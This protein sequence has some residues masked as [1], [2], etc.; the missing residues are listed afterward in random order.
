MIQDRS[1]LKIIDNSGSKIGVC[2]KIISGFKKRY[3]RMGELIFLSIKKLRN[4]RRST[5][6]TKKGEIYSAL[7][8]RTKEK[9]KSFCGDSLNFFDN[10]SVLINKKNKFIG[11]RIFGTI[12]KFL[13]KTKFLRVT[14]LSSGVS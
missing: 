13:R 2:F 4:K 1:K 10:A 11:T 5:S 3:A 14:T 9:K 8:L 12:P 7:L 6:K